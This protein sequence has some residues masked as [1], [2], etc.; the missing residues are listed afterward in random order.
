MDYK[1][2]FLKSYEYMDVDLID[3]DCG[4][5]CGY[6]CCRSRHE[7]GKVLGIY[8]LPFEYENMQKGKGLIDESHLEIHTK[9]AYNLPV[10]IKKLYYGYCKDNKNCIR[11]IR[12]IQ[13]RTFPF[14]P[15]LE[16]GSLA[17]T[18]YIMKSH[19]I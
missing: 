11:D 8:F 2:I 1:E 3:G 15:H 12:P 14:V 7:N 5:L 6:H 9:I 13:C 10:G 18:K 16:E 19:A 17:V 4:K